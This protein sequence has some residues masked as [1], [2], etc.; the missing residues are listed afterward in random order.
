MWIESIIKVAMGYEYLKGD[1]VLNV[2]VNV[3]LIWIS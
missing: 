2:L 3:V 1:Q